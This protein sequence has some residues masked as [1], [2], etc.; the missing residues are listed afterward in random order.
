MKYKKLLFIMVLIIS[1]MLSGITVN[2]Q[3]TEFAGGTGSVENPYQISNK[4]QLDHVRNY[5]NANYILINDI[6]FTD[7]DFQTGGQFYNDG[8][9][10]VEIPTLSG[11]LNG[12]GHSIVNLYCRNSGV[13]FISEIT[14]SGALINMEFKNIDM[15]AGGFEGDAMSN[16]QAIVKDN[17]GTIENCFVHGK[18]GG[19][20]VN[21]FAYKN[22][23]TISRC[24]SNLQLLGCMDSWAFSSENY[25]IIEN[26]LNL[27]VDTFY[28]GNKKGGIATGTGTIRNCVSIGGHKNMVPFRDNANADCY[29]IATYNVKN[30]GKATAVPI[31]RLGEKDAFPTLDFQQIWEMSSSQ[32]FPVLKNNPSYDYFTGLANISKP[33]SN[34]KVEGHSY[35]SIKLSW[36]PVPGASAY[37]ITSNK[38]WQSPLNYEDII[39]KN[40]EYIDQ[41][42]AVSLAV[43]GYPGN[44]KPNFDYYVIPLFENN[45][46]YFFG[47][48]SAYGSGKA[49]DLSSESEYAD[50]T[51]P[52]LKS[53]ELL[54]PKAFKPG[55]CDLRIVADD[56]GS[57]IETI[58]VEI[59][60]NTTNISHTFYLDQ[61]KELDSVFKFPV[62]ME[63]DSSI[64]DVKVPVET[65]DYIIRSIVLKDAAGNEEHIGDTLG[66]VFGAEILPDKTV[67]IDDEFDVEF[68]GYLSNISVA[69]QLTKM[70]EGKTV[71]LKI[72]EKSRGI[73]KKEIL[74]AIKGQDKTIVVY[75]D[76]NASMQWVFYGKDITGA[77]KDININVK[78]EK[79]NGNRFGSKYDIIKLEYEDNGKLPGIIQFRLK[80]KYISA[81]NN[82][83]DDLFLYYDNGKKLNLEQSNCPIIK[84][85][86]NNWCYVDL[87]HNSTFYLSSEKLTKYEGTA[88]KGK[89][90]LSKSEYVYTGKVKNPKL[91]VK[92]SDGKTLKKGTDYTVST[93]KGRKAIGKYTYTVT[94]KG[95]YSGKKKVT[96]TIKPTA[97]TLKKPAATKKTITVK[98][99]KGTKAQASGYQV[100][101]ATDKKFKNAV[102]KYSVKSYKKT[103]KKIS[104]LKT[105][106]TYYVK[107]RT[108]KTVKG[109]K[110]YSDWSKVKQIKTK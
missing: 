59:G 72:N 43:S 16:I 29:Y 38:N 78:S 104:K 82:S 22:Y 74:D 102:K 6:V 5:P 48:Y 106:K 34:L 19:V 92:T 10:W 7:S 110:I 86:S 88:F 44:A 20:Y 26:C 49:V 76:D 47:T 64:S 40:T 1:V 91:T 81:I 32:G 18:A 45:D 80:S 101:I 33:I 90:K 24:V 70:P 14:T 4:Y 105:K 95:N 68:T 36:D 61:V 93:P 8:E 13:Y 27:S 69:D 67:H 85:G 71:V 12:N 21:G 83:K 77:T 89:I 96:L 25:G 31:E 55:T 30:A 75:A 84:D 11:T 107:I 9:G 79:I 46:M 62:P 52:V 37:Y 109:I 99:K 28:W 58:T 41:N 23:G 39:T 60:Y 100:M 56:F 65:G 98:W 108:Y 73:L 51:V 103:S 94:F 66:G 15:N 57:G 53:I 3:E 35:N 42:L 2:A 97:P 54:S 87:S 17:Y 63:I 50:Y